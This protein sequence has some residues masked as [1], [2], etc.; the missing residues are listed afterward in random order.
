MAVVVVDE[1]IMN[2]KG[3]DND[4]AVTPTKDTIQALKS[5]IL[6]RRLA[7]G[8]ED[9]PDLFAAPVKREVSSQ[10]TFSFVDNVGFALSIAHSL[11]YIL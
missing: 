7:N 10:D 8:E 2:M 3:E 9:I 1:S 6:T 11:D 4:G 5:S